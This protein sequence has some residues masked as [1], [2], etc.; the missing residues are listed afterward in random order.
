M[1]TLFYPKRPWTTNTDRNLNPYKRAGKIKEWRKAYFDLATQAKIP[2]QRK[3]AVVIT[4]VLPDRRKQ[5]T[6]AC[7]P[8]AKAAID[9]LIDAGVI[10]DDTREYLEFILFKPYEYDKGNPGLRV[11]IIPDPVPC[12]TCEIGWTAG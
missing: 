7:N 1:W 4:P 3:I 10:L 8:A 6:A 11:E 9:G 12:K 2:L 5:D